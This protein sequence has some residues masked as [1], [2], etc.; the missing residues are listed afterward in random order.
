MRPRGKAAKMCAMD[1][2]CEKPEGVRLAQAEAD[3]LDRYAGETGQSRSMPVR[4]AVRLLRVLT[5]PMDFQARTRLIA[6]LAKVEVQDV[7]PDEI[8][9]WAALAARAMA[10]A[11]LSPS[12]PPKRKAGQKRPG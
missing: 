7:T 5:E 1:N 3:W 9:V 12:S 10:V 2:L 11:G 8:E 6:K 4:A